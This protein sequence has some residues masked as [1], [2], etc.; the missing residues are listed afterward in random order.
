MGGVAEAAEDE[1]GPVD[2]GFF[3]GEPGAASGDIG[4]GLGELGDLRPDV[5]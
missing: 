1:V 4:G 5:G 2:E 3:G